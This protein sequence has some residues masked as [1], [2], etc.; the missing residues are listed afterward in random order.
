MP[1]YSIIYYLEG[2]TQ[3][4]YISFPDSYWAMWA[5]LYSLD[6]YQWSFD[7]LESVASLRQNDK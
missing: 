6:N 2:G 5:F 3:E 1:I 4:R 7:T